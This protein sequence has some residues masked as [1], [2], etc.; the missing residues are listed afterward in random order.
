MGQRINLGTQ[1]QDVLPETNGGAGPNAGLRFSDAE[2]PSGAINGSNVTFTLANAPNPAASLILFLNKV[3]QIQGTDYTLSGAT[4]TMAVAP[5]GSPSF[6]GWYRYLGFGNSLAIF[7]EQMTMADAFVFNLPVA[8][9]P[10]QPSDQL[11]MSDAIKIGLGIQLSD[12]MV[13]VEAFIVFDRPD[14]LEIAERMLMT[15]SVVIAL[16]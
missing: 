4:I 11:V 1:V 10:N 15:D 8:A 7:G 5:S 13:L 14:K 12:Q 16:H 9:L 2:T 3:L 6:L